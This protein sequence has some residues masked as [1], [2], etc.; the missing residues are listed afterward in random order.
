MGF[1]FGEG[2]GMGCFFEVRFVGFGWMF[3]FEVAVLER[4]TPPA[5]L[6]RGVLR[7]CFLFDN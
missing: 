6:E 3:W 5:P 7:Y 2:R 4:N 1:P